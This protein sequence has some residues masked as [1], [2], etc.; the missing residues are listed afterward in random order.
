MSRLSLSLDAEAA[1]PE[2][3]ANGESA[4]DVDSCAFVVV[5]ASGDLAKKK[6]YPALFKLYLQNLL[7][8]KF[9]V[10]GYARSANDDAAFREKMRGW[11]EKIAA[12]RTAQLDSFLA[13]LVYFQGQYN[14]PD[15]FARLNGD[16]VAWEHE[17][18]AG[19]HNRVCVSAIPAPLSLLRSALFA[20]YSCLLALLGAN[21]SRAGRAGSTSPSRPRCSPPPP[22]RSRAPAWPRLAGRAS[23]SRSHSATISCALPPAPRRPPPAASSR[24]RSITA[25]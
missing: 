18:G 15:D 6:T 5:G 17:Q 4:L 25:P 3:Q 12:G 14:S 10:W 11:L 8:A 9:K 2:P 1:E 20:L 24:S 22:A 23:S 21:S 19:A 13:M 7:P 16:V